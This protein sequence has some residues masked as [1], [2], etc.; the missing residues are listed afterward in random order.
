MPGIPSSRMIVCS[1]ASPPAP[2]PAARAVLTAAIVLVS[3]LAA[4]P[5]R[6][7]EPPQDDAPLDVRLLD[8]G[9]R[10]VLS[11][12]GVLLAA[13]QI[14]PVQAEAG[15]VLPAG[16][17]WTDAKPL[18]KNSR[19]PKQADFPS[20]DP[21][22]LIS[23]LLQVRRVPAGA[24][25][26]VSPEL[27]EAGDAAQKNPARELE[28]ATELFPDPGKEKEKGWPE[29]SAIDTSGTVEARTWA[30]KLPE[31]GAPAFRA[32]RL[33][34]SLPGRPRVEIAR[35]GPARWSLT[36]GAASL[37]LRQKLLPDPREPLKPGTFE[38]FL[39][40]E[41]DGLEA[42]V[43]PVSL[44]RE[45]VPAWDFLEGHFRVYAGGAD[46]YGYD[47]LLVFAEIAFPEDENA[48][49]DENL[50]PRMLQVP[51]F[52]RE[53]PSHAPAEGEFRFRFAPPFPGTYAVRIAAISPG[54]VIR[55]EAVPFRAGPAAS[56]GF[57]RAK[58][59]DRAFRY[60]DGSVVFP[61]GPNL[62]WPS[63]PGAAES[64]RQ[65]FRELARN[66]GNAA[67]IWLSSWGM[68]FEGP[69]A[70]EFSSDAAEALDGI[71]LAAQARDIGLIF[72]AENAHDIKVNS[73]THPY[74]RE[75]GGP[76]AAPAEF[77]R[78]AAA[79][80]LF[81]RRLTYLAARYGAYRS[82][83]SWELMNEADEAWLSLKSEPDDPRMP[84]LEA[85]TARAARRDVL[86][87]A[88]LLAQHLKAMDGV[89]HPVMLTV[90]LPPEYAWMGLQ[91]LADLDA[92]QEHAYIPEAADA[93]DDLAFDEA[94][95]IAAWAAASREPGRPH[96]PYFLGEFGY[97]ALHDQE[98]AK[99][100]AEA[101]AADRNARDTEGL[102]L[103]NASFAALA[104][105]MAAA[106][107]NWWWDRHI[108]K[109]RLWGCY[110][111]P[112]AFAEALGRLATRDGPGNLRAL[113]NDAEAAKG[114]GVRVLGRAGK[115]GLCVWIQ[116]RRSTWSR[117]LEKNEPA[118]P[119]I[120]ELEIHL[121]ALAPGEYALQWLDTWNG[122]KLGR[123][124]LTV[125]AEKDGP[126]KGIDLKCPAFHRDIAVWIEPASKP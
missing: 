14:R 48:A 1:M 88:A 121:P 61:V 24:R 92:I 22:K 80:K 40:D 45:Q 76:L 122:E 3:A 55:G 60:D 35:S 104:S 109:L 41:R 32:T 28:L 30:G 51:C 101:A 75:L 39:G 85:D 17:K 71:F 90:A 6:A 78:N 86:A 81:K 44:D 95:Q 21:G 93:R 13:A 110:K 10:V 91:K 115:S 100:G 125:E 108:E 9:A 46:P 77:F 12:K 126:P 57:L 47:E 23:L 82:L 29:L 87:W 65:R 124:V 63:K 62:A 94:A 96:K 34:F 73:A 69:H 20:A 5:A 27:A 98:L 116:D 56:R 19:T 53:G 112:A 66:G 31:P 68:P 7:E 4:L 114:S 119:E 2:L 74:F 106:P 50:P 54:G 11:R 52:Y 49:A 103:H 97:V 67:R 16:I 79:I 99:A 8:D 33:S 70:G 105:G 25:V 83:W 89:Q 15:P 102:L 26:L 18:E 36:K 58:A 37:L 59:G 113:N 120:K 72:V 117:K 42:G 43:S 64:Y 111:G 118:P 123:Q 107:M 38:F 84:V